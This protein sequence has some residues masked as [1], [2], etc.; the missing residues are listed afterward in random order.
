MTRPFTPHTHLF[1]TSK[2]LGRVY[3]AIRM[4]LLFTTT[5]C[6]PPFSH[7]K[8]CHILKYNMLFH[9]SMVW[10][11]LFTDRQ[12]ISSVHFI[13][14]NSRL[15]QALPF[16]L[17]Q[18][19]ALISALVQIILFYVYP[20]CLSHYIEF[21]EGRDIFFILVSSAPSMGPSVL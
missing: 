11:T 7:T 12:A 14:T 10:G 3:K 13:N 18:H 8:L 15:S 6:M 19:S 21:P 1:K 9:T 5:S 16:V 20:A 2:F 17:L 4:V